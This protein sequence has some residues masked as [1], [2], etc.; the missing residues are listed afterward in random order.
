MKHTS[1]GLCE[2]GLAEMSA[3]VSRRIPPFFEAKGR[4]HPK[5]NRPAPKG[6]YRRRKPHTAAV[7]RMVQRLLGVGLTSAAH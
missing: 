5:R 2:L 7:S 4:P 1:S 6:A 3:W